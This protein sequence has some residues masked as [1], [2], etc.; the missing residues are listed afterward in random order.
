MTLTWADPDND[1]IDGY[2]VRHARSSVNLPDWSDDHN[3]DGSGPA[4]TRHRVTGLTNGSEYTFDVRAYNEAG[5]G[6]S[7]SARATPE[8]PPCPRLTIDAISDVTVNVGG[9]VSLQAN[10]RGGCGSTRYSISGAPR[11]VNIN[12]TTGA[13]SGRVPNSPATHNVT[14]TARDRA[15]NTDT[16]K[17]NIIVVCPSITYSGPM[18]ITVTTGGSKT[19]TATASGGQSPYTF[20][21]TSGPSWV[22]IEEDGKI[23][24]TN[25]PNSPGQHT[26]RVSIADNRGCTGTGEFTVKVTEEPC[27]EV[28]IDDIADVKVKVGGSISITPSARGGCGDLDYSKTGTLPDG[29]TFD[30]ETGA[31]SGEP[32]AAGQNKLT[33]TAMDTLGNAAT[34]PE[35]T[36]TVCEPVG[37]GSISTQDRAGRVVRR[38]LR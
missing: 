10:A 23:K 12:E 35:F 26:V 32:T 34:T 4:T 24:V 28:E 11:N 36:I 13:I 30:S 1:T 22:T 6:V 8:V 19:V 37:I 31:V 14:V 27:A 2:Q 18:T 5:V 3:V 15:G 16:E 25:A 7:D 38:R 9:S 21:K 17:F 20:T 33:V 29:V